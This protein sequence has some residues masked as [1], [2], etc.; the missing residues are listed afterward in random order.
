MEGG[1]SSLGQ[2]EWIV[3]A[4][5]NGG[6]G[7]TL[8]CKVDHTMPKGFPPVIRGNHGLLHIP[9]LGEGLGQELIGDRWVEIG[10]LH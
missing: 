2:E 1:R 6:H 3:A 7:L 8:P 5:L 4:L 10:D 9:K